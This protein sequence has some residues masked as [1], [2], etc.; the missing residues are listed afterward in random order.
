MEKGAKSDSPSFTLDTEIRI[1]II[2][3]VGAGKSAVG[4]ALLNEPDCFVSRQS[5]CSVTK[6]L[7]SGECTRNGAKFFIVD[8]PGLKG[9]EDD[10]KDALKCLTRCILATSP[11][12]HCIVWVISASQRIEEVDIQLFKDI[13]KLLGKNAYSYMVVVFTHVQ[14]SDLKKVLNGCTPVDKFCKQCNERY[15]CFGDKTDPDLEKQQVDKFF[16]MLQ[17]SF[18]INSKEGRPFYKHKLFD[19]ALDI[20]KSDAEKLMKTGIYKNDS[21][22]ALTQARTD[23]LNGHSPHDQKMLLLVEGSLFYRIIR[24]ILGIFGCSIL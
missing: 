15:L 3:K 19:Q 11:G 24:K 16:T 1:L 14:P 2:G 22:K 4:N 10:H 12:F 7:N 9:L 8:T 6:E 18:E 5:F 20:L 13:E 17:E 23:A 21:E